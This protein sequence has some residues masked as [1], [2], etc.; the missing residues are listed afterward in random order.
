MADHVILL[1]EDNANDEELTLMALRNHNIKNEI[2]VVRDGQEA[3]DYL[4]GT[5]AHS[6]RDM[7]VQPQ[8]VLLDINLPKVNGLD[9]LKRIREN[10]RTRTQPVVILTSSTEE[11]DRLTAYKHFA[12]SYI[13]KPVDFDQ[14]A[15]AVRELGLY[16]LVLN[17]PPP[18]PRSVRG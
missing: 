6:G 16:W 18:R 1:V 4:F 2:V 5:G 7:N 14:F 13:R 8:V 3:L 11:R 12:N 9:V 17:Q 10:E 15:E